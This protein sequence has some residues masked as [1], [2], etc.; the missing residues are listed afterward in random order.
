MNAKAHLIGGFTLGV[1]TL[2]M[3]LGATQNIDLISLATVPYV[4]ATTLGALLPDI[5]HRSSTIGRKAKITSYVTSKVCGHR[6]MT[7]APILITAAWLVL[8][9]FLTGFSG[10]LLTG[11][12]VGCMSHIFLD[13]LTRQ[14]IPLLYPITSK[15][16]HLLAIR[17]GGKLEKI[18]SMGMIIALAFICLCFFGII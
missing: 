1:I 12:Y 11:V 3:V 18:I 5:D 10:L 8:G 6:G 9:L 17:T 7:H 2:P 14:G 13:G 4:A 16:Y 15:K